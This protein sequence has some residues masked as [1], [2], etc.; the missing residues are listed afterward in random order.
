VLQGLGRPGV[1]LVPHQ[2]GRRRVH[3]LGEDPLDVGDPRLE[4]ADEPFPL[5]RE[6][7][8]PVDLD[9]ERHDLAAGHEPGVL[10]DARRHRHLVDG[11]TR[12][13]RFPFDAER[14]H[15]GVLE[16]RIELARRGRTAGAIAGLQ[17]RH[18]VED[19]RAMWIGVDRADLPEHRTIEQ[20]EA[21]AGPRTTDVCGQP[22]RQLGHFLRR[23]VGVLGCDAAR[24]GGGRIGRSC[25]RL[26]VGFPPRDLLVP[27]DR[28]ERVSLGRDREDARAAV[29]RDGL[30]GT[31]AVEERG[32]VGERRE[33]ESLG[34]R[35]GERVELRGAEHHAA[36]ARHVELR[37]AHGHDRRRTADRDREPR[38]R[39]QADHVVELRVPLHDDGLG[40]AGRRDRDRPRGALERLRRCPADGPLGA[41]RFEH[42]PCTR[43]CERARFASL[44]RRISLEPAPANAEREPAGVLVVDPGRQAAGLLARRFA[45]CRRSQRDA[46]TD[47]DH[48]TPRGRC[49]G[50]E[51]LG[52]ERVGFFFRGFDRRAGAGRGLARLHD[53]RDLVCDQ[54]DPLGARRIELSIGHE[55]V[56][57]DRDRARMVRCGDRLP[58][59]VVVD[60][61]VAERGRGR[62][63]EVNP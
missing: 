45:G 7:G 15:L 13:E 44:P 3:L 63:L 40:L 12:L 23:Q 54:R 38:A 59:L 18:R 46:A 56:A 28:G 37:G 31:E 8:R 51:E 10:L 16:Q 57:A 5:V 17:P 41:Q 20:L 35:R 24:Y 9:R 6:L 61:N 49:P 19:E 48:R 55:N 21:R 1:A 43:R 27:E 50:L 60:A 11:A 52:G 14:L 30:R 39:W 26:A 36:P 4:P 47:R 2:V 42:R 29:R 32:R 62:T 58:V 25:A 34:Q 22:A 33:A 53:V